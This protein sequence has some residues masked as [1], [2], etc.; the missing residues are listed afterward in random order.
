[1]PILGIALVAALAVIGVH[2]ALDPEPVA[3][4][5]LDFATAPE[6]AWTLSKDRLT[7]A[8]D[9]V[10]LPA[11]STLNTY[12]GYGS[13][14]ATASYIVAALGKIDPTLVEQ[15][16]PVTDVTL[17]GVDRVDG[18]SLWRTPIGRVDQCSMSTGDSYL[19]CWSIRN[20]L[21]VDPESGN[22]AGSTSTDFDIGSVQVADDTVHVSGTVTP[23]GTPEQERIPVLTVGTVSDIDAEYYREFDPLGEYS[24]GYASP[25]TGL[26]TVGTSNTP[27]GPAVTRVVDTDTADTLFTY[28]A[29]SLIPMSPNLVR[30]QNGVRAGLVGTE[31]LLTRDGTF[32]TSIPVP[33]SSALTYVG[34]RADDSLPLFLGDGAY[35]AV[36]GAE[37]WRNPDMIVRES[38][39][40]TSA[41]KAV[42]GQTIIVTS[43][44]TQTIT[45]LNAT[46]GER[47]WQTL[48]Q[49]A[50]WVRDGATDGQYYVFSDYT[51]THAIRARDGVVVWSLPLTGGADP[52][53][54]R[55]GTT[56]GQLSISWR[57]QFVVYR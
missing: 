28:A 32:A 17:V 46:T 51:G 9:E 55:V 30:A 33:S 10:V 27:A 39:G 54:V 52:R 26:T 4:P 5:P 48:W 34:A 1:L 36:T 3:L 12:Y 11:Q 37:L 18:S 35:D 14:M 38:G 49:D 15:G 53:E 22:V 45:G 23:A 29:E 40:P 50:Y 7:N 21:F 47:E 24:Y 43:P 19:A 2:I 8:E 41:V 42:V 56:A 6:Q 57:N 25:R 13:P 16:A 20:V 31:E 44:E